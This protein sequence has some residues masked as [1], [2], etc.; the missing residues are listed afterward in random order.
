LA[1]ICDVAELISR[2]KLDWASL[3]DRAAKTDS[4]RMFLLGVYLAESLLGPVLPDHVKRRCASDKRILE[5]AGDVV[6]H[7]FNG[8]VHIPATSGEIFMY[9]VGVRSSWR[10]RARYFIYMLRPTDA[11]LSARALPRHWEFAYYL[12]RP[13][14]LL[15]KPGA[16]G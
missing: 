2:H 11:D 14:R 7:L 10:A 12:M 6:A 16:N 15:L 4:E 3:L 13:F 1:W 9:N 8:A 5:L